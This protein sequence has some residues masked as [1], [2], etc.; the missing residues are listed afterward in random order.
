MKISQEWI[1][2][3]ILWSGMHILANSCNSSTQEGWRHKD[4]G[5]K[6]FLG[7]PIWDHCGTHEILSQNKAKQNKTGKQK[8]DNSMKIMSKNVKNSSKKCRGNINK[9]TEK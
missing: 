4:R 1:Q 8:P 6:M 9:L 2:Y 7:Y 5:C 3:K